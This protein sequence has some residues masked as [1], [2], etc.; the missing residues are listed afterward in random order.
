M[1]RPIVRTNIELKFVLRFLPIAIPNL[2]ESRDLKEN[3]D[4][5]RF[6]LNS[7]SVQLIWSAD[8][9]YQVEI[10][11]CLLLI[12]ILNLAESKDL[13]KNDDFWRFILN[14]LPVWVI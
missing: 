1:R 13:K 6:F 8:N 5:R 11:W 7:L 9:E 10:V 3:D 12:A 4:F 2:A 14:S